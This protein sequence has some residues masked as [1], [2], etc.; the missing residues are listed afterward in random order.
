MP[1][2]QALAV[3]RVRSAI[4]FLPENCLVLTDQPDLLHEVEPFPEDLVVFSIVPGGVRRASHLQIALPIV[5]P[6]TVKEAL[7]RVGKPVKHVRVL[8]NLSKAAS[9]PE[10]LMKEAEALMALHDLS[11][12]VLQQCFETLSQGETSFI[13][14]FLEAL[15]D[16]EHH[17]FIGLF[18]GLIKCARLEIPDSVTFGLFTS[19]ESVREGVQQAYLEST[20]HRSLPVVVY[21][22]GIRKSIILQE[23]NAELSEDTP[24]Q[25]DQNAVVLAVGGARGITAELLKAV[26]RHCQSR[27]YLIGTNPLQ[28]YPD[29]VFGGS[30]EEWASRRPLYIREQRTLHPEK[31]I[32][33]INKGFDRLIEARVARKNMS[34]MAEYCGREH[35]HYIVCDVTNREKVTQVVAEILQ[36]EGKVDLLM[37]A[38]GLNR[39]A[40][41]REKNFNVF[42]SIR[43]LKIQAYQ[44]LKNAFKECHPRLWCNFGSLIGLGGQI[45][46]VDYASANDFLVSA[47]TY[48]CREGASPFSPPP[49]EVTLGWT[50]WGSVGLAANP[51]AKAHF[52]RAGTY[53]AMTTEE[54]IH[55]FMREVNQR[56]HVPAIIYVGEAEKK[57]LNKSLP[58][59]L[60]E[61]AQTKPERA[62]YLD[63]VLFHRDD[64]VV[65]ERVFDLKRDSYLKNHLVNGYATLPGMFVT[66]IAAEAA[67]HLVPGMHVI[68]FE[69]IQFKNF[70]RVYNEDHPST[71]RIH[72]KIVDQTDEQVIVH[73]RILTDIVSPDGKVLKSDKEH[74][75]AKVVLRREFP[76][77]PRWETWEEMG[78]TPV[79]DPYHAT[80]SPIRLTD[81]FVST[82]DTRL[83]PRGKRARYTLHLPAD[84]PVFSRFLMPAMLFDGLA[85]VGVLD[86]VEGEYIPLVAFLSI[87][88]LDIYEKTNDC[89]LAAQSEQIELSVTPREATL[90]SKSESNRFVAVRSD[91]TLLLQIN[92]LF[93]KLIGYM[94]RDTEQFFPPDHLKLTQQGE[95]HMSREQNEAI[96]RRFIQVWGVG[97]LEMVDEL[98]APD[99]SVSYPLL[100]D[101]LHGRE[102]FK[103]TLLAVNT[104]FPITEVVCEEVFAQGDKVLLRWSVRATH[105]GVFLGIPPTGK[106]V[107]WTGITVYHIVGGKV[108]EERGE[109]NTLGVLQQIGGIPPLG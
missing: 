56:H 89:Q 106:Q 37:N 39:P 87:E 5:T 83:H 74:F 40:P 46:E 29:E 52:E 35:V 24:I 15:P 41:I 80:A 66:E 20:A 81:L 100:G 27:L 62:F 49:A 42:R 9:A 75:E 94:H 108:V 107:V 32:A 63:R 92:N 28:S 59:I 95:Y 76:P 45:G 25:L 96:A 4:P 33:T 65:F 103:Q 99:I 61:R 31:N 93:G 79:P 47:S 30:D 44:N 105:T 109:S 88:R 91:G 55:H 17:P 26:A 36:A 22:Q 2:L 97:N 78:E 98:A 54:G 43:D 53:S 48:A 70:L 71:K 1:V 84:H 82:Q 8:T 18:G 72:A 67:T 34:K 102:A 60:S 11:F 3:D 69:D 50:L 104:N 23:A 73:V 12:L 51:L 68:A 6:D 38:A 13:S 14:L 77:A 86:L 101:T 85:R 21:A 10:C 64:E 16:G 90:L 57:A 7:A 19:T 58:G